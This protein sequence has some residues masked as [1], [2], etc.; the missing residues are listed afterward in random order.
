MASGP[1]FKNHQTLQQSVLV[2]TPYTKRHT[3][4]TTVTLTKESM[5]NH[6][7]SRIQVSNDALNKASLPTTVTLTKESVPAQSNQHIQTSN[8]NVFE[9]LRSMYTRTSEDTELKHK[10]PNVTV[11]THNPLIKGRVRA[12]HRVELA[13]TH[14]LSTNMSSATFQQPARMSDA[15]ERFDVGDIIGSRMDM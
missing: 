15:L 1:V 7:K 8:V 12:P 10:A 14:K 2:P 6:T 11:A 9:K 5:P 13:R 3:F 4:P